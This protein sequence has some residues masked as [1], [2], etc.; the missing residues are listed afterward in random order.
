MNIEVTPAYLLRSYIWEVLQA[1]DP[2]IWNT[3]NYGGLTPIV[4]LAEEAELS[5]YDGP[6]IVY[7]Y[8]LAPVRDI[9]ARRSGSMTFAIYD[10]NF[11]R[12]TK[13]VAI[14]A[15]ALG[16]LDESARDVN[17]FTTRNPSYLGMT[18]AYVDLG[19]VEGGTPEQ[20]EGGRQSALVNVRFEYHVDYDV[21]TSV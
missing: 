15:E 7:G 21:I 1:N 11:R 13:T 18:F 3:N 19:F 12:L 10:Q 16:R 20:T 6:H 5:Q 2:G 17:N 4:P 9:H 14:I 8:A